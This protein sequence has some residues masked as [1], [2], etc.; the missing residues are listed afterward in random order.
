MF[1]PYSADPSPFVLSKFR[2]PFVIPTPNDAIRL[3]QRTQLSDDPENV[4]Y[5]VGT[6]QFRSPYQTKVTPAR[7]P[8]LLPFPEVPKAPPPLRK[9]LSATR[10]EPPT[11]MAFSPPNVPQLAETA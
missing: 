1:P 9:T 2:G 5:V 11:A 10:A 8:P 6:L 4:L 3:C 7:P